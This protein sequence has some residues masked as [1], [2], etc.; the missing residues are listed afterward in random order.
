MKNAVQIIHNKQCCKRL[1]QNPPSSPFS[2]GGK[3]HLNPS[4]PPQADSP[5]RRQGSGEI[6]KMLSKLFI[7]K[8]ILDRYDA[9]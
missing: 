2:K 9:G 3:Q 5:G 6:F 8:F 7:Q 1:L 4:F